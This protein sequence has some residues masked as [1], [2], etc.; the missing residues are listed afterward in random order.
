MKKLNVLS[1][2]DGMSCGRIAL[3][4]AN[5]E[6]DNYFS[7]EIDKYAIQVADDNYPEDTKNRLG[8]VLDLT[9]E[10]LLALPKID[11]LIGGSPCQGFSLA[12]TRKGSSTKCGIDVTTLEQYLQLKKD[13]FEFQGQSYL[14]WEFV[15]IWKLLKP[16]YFF[17]ENV[18]VEKK[19]LKMFNEAMETEPIFINSKDYSAQNRPRYYWTNIVKSIKETTCNKIVYDILEENPLFH[20]NYSNW[21]TNKW[22]D[23]IRLDSFFNAKGKAS[24]LTSAMAKGQKATYCVNDKKEIHKYT[25]KECERLQTVADDYTSCVSNSQRYKMLGNGWTIDVIVEFFKGLR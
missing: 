3:E 8:N 14:F 20:N 5:I 22:G 1:L 21:M 18:K 4:R 24:C 2:F 17:L 10:Q 11:L 7:S 25:P 12:G 6:I 16:K 9:D 13:N 23:K 19:W 15:R